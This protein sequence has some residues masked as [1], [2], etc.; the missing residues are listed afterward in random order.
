MM[1]M[2]SAAPFESIEEMTKVWKI[3]MHR[4]DVYTHSNDKHPLNCTFCDNKENNAV[5]KRLQATAAKTN[6]LNL[7]SISLFCL[8]VYLTTLEAADLSLTKGL[9][10]LKEAADQGDMNAARYLAA[11]YA[12]LHQN[13]KLFQKDNVPSAIKYYIYAFKLG[14]YDALNELMLILRNGIDNKI[15]QN[16]T[17][18]QELFLNLFS[19]AAAKNN[20]QNIHHLIRCIFQQ[21]YPTTENN[22][23]LH[24][25]IDI[26]KTWKS[27]KYWRKEYMDL[28]KNYLRR[29]IE[30]KNLG[31]IYLNRAL[32]LLPKE[33]TYISPG[34]FWI[35][36]T[37]TINTVEI[38]EMR[39]T[40]IINETETIKNHLLPML[41]DKSLAATDFLFTA[42]GKLN[43]FITILEE[44]FVEHLEEFDKDGFKLLITAV[45]KKDSPDLNQS[46]ACS[47]MILVLNKYLSSLR[48]QSSDSSFQIKA[49]FITYIETIETLIT[50]I[51]ERCLPELVN[52]N[53]KT[54]S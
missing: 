39:K 34:V 45:G 19:E 31:A 24:R 5:L 44:E 20:E 1:N 50:Q 10:S 46:K 47:N 4:A 51:M 28:V 16:L 33:G 8:G 38:D 6:P 41:A 13:A 11:I 29:E 21:P 22:N 42:V 27:S 25:I 54:L 17:Q 53:S 35:N 40:V 2:F 49:S 43:K 32:D 12:G 30:K 37:L 52:N 7:Q 48:Q 23:C 26:F 36:P 3:A 18:W 14:N 15:P 9:N